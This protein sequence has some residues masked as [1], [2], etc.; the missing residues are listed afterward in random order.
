MEVREAELPECA[1]PSW[2]SGT[3]ESLKASGSIVYTGRERLLPNQY[4]ARQEPRSPIGALAGSF[5]SAARLSS[6]TSGRM[7]TF[8][9]TVS[10]VGK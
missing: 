2:S 10:K 1:L 8:T 6:G 7:L 5:P 4:Q 3:S 9:E